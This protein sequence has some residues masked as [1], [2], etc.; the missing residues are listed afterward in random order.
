LGVFGYVWVF[1]AAAKLKDLLKNMIKRR[2]FKNV[3]NK[4]LEY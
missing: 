3:K 2:T 1:R 4:G